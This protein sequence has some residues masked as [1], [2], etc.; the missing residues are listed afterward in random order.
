MRRC[1]NSEGVAEYSRTISIW[2]IS[3]ITKWSQVFMYMLK[4]RIY[5]V[6]WLTMTADQ[7]E[8]SLKLDF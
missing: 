4:K 7:E 2:E 8:L 6:H 5:T 1:V 3:A